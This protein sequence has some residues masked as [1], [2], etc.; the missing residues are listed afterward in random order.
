VGARFR[1]LPHLLGSLI[2]IAF[3]LTPVI[4]T[5]AMLKDRG[6]AFV[7]IVNPLYYLIELVRYPLLNNA[8]PPREVLTVAL[9]YCAVMGI[10]ALI[11]VRKMSHRIVYIL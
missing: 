2:Q 7:Y 6:L 3:Y 8:H 1:D 4:F 5:V 9:G 11:V 10:T